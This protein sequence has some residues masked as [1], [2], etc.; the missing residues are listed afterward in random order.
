MKIRDF[1]VS[2]ILIAVWN[3]L[4]LGQA[5]VQPGTPGSKP[6]AQLAS[7]V[8][9]SASKA[10]IAIQGPLTGPAPVNL[11]SAGL[12]LSSPNYKTAGL[13]DVAFGDFNGDGNV[14]VVNVDSSTC[15]TFMPGDGKG[16]FSGAPV[17]SCVLPNTGGNLIVAGDFNN[18][19]ILDVAVIASNCCNPNNIYLMFAQG[20]G[21]GTF[22]YKNTI[23]FCWCGGG[24][25]LGYGEL[26]T[27]L[28]VADLNRDGNLDLVMTTTGGNVNHYSS[29][30]FLGSGNFN[31]SQ[32]GLVG[33][34]SCPGIAAGIVTDLNGDGLVDLA[35]TTSACGLH[36]LDVYLGNGDGTFQTP[37]GYPTTT[38]NPSCIAY[39]DINGDGVTDIA[40]TVGAGGNPIAAFLGNG[41]GT[42]G[43][44]VN[45]PSVYNPYCVAMGDFNG[46]GKADAIV[47]SNYSGGDVLGVQFSNGDGTFQAPVQYAVIT[48]PQRIFVQDVNGD[49]HPDW[50]SIGQGYLYL[51]VGLGSGHGGFLAAVDDYSTPGTYG[52]GTTNAIAAADFNKD[53]NLDY[54]TV[55]GGGV[56]ISIGDGAGNFA[57]AVN[58]PAGPSPSQFTVGDFNK[59]GYPDIAVTQQNGP[60]AVYVLLNNKNGTFASPVSYSVGNGPYLVQTGDF[61]KDGNLD[62][63]VTNV[64]DG[65]VSVLLGN[66]DGT[67]QGQKVSTSQTSGSYLA[68]ADFNG[69]GELDLAVALYSASSTNISILL[70][71]GDG[72]FQAPLTTTPAP[73]LATGLAAG[74]FDADGKI[75][76]V[77]AADSI[78]NGSVG[79]GGAAIY[80]GL[81]NGSFAKV[82]DYPTVPPGLNDSNFPTFRGPI[83]L[84]DLNNDGFLDIVAPNYGS[85]ANGINLGPAILLGKGD[86]TFILN[87]ATAPVAGTFQGGVALGDFNH[88]GLLDLAVRNFDPFGGQYLNTVTMLLS[89]E[90]T[91]VVL[92]SS[93]NPSVQGQPVTFT[94]TVVTSFVGLPTPTGTIT[95]ELGSTNVPVAL[96]NGVATYTTSTLSLGGT[97]VYGAYSGDSNFVAS[98]SLGLS[99]QVNPAP[100][101]IIT[102]TLP[103]AVQNVSYS[104]SV[105]ASG[106]IAPY[107]FN[108]FSGSLPTGLSLGGNGVISGTPTG[109]PGTSNFTVLVKDAENPTQSATANLSITVAINLLITTTSLP[110]GVAANAYNASIAASGGTP[111]YNFALSN[112]TTL[113]AGLSL[114]AAGAISG[115]PATPGTSNFT[116]QVTDSANPAQSAT[117]NLSITITSALSITTTSLPNG[118]QGSPYNTSVTATGGIAPYTFV[119]S[120]GNLPLGLSLSSSGVFSGTP[121]G[122]GTSNFTVKASDSSSPPQI[123]TASFSISVFNSL[124][125]TTTK[126]PGGVTGTSYSSSV[127][128]SG[129][130]PP[131]TFTI[132][133]GSLP[134]GLGISQGGRIS[135]TP[136]GSAGTSTFT[137]QAR[138]SAN[139]PQTST[140]ILSITIYTGLSITTTTLPNG[141]VGNV[142][143][144]KVTAF[145]GT[146][147]YAF[148][149]VSGTLPTGLT[150][151]TNGTISGTASSA[152]PSSFTVQATDS[153]VPVQTAMANLSIAVNPRLSISTT[154]LPTAVLG[155]PYN[156]TVSATGGVPPYAFSDT[157][158]SLPGGLTLS[159][160]GVIS[161][162]PT[163]LG[164]SNF[165]VQAVDSSVPS[166]L[167]TSKLSIK[168]TSNIAIT[169]PSVPNAVFNTPYNA[170]IT[171]TGGTAPYTFTTITGSLPAGLSLS[172]GGV[173][174]GTP[175]STGT[176]T[177]TVQAQDSSTPMLTATANFSI[178]VSG[179]LAITTPALLPSGVA[180]VPY[181]TK[182]VAAGGT[183]PYNFTISGGSLLQGLTLNSS[184]G[185]ISGTVPLNTGGAAAF[186]VQVT[187][188]STPV[189][190]ATSGF[191]L[192][193][194][195]PLSI[196]TTTLPGAAPGMPY[197]ATISTAGGS[198]PITFS[199]V[200]G[201]LPAGLSMSA[202]GVISGTP[203]GTNG[204][205]NFTLQAK[206]SAVPAQT[207]S[208]RLSITVDSPLVITTTS[209][210]NG[211]VGVPY[212]FQMMATGGLQPY[213]WTP[214]P[215]F[216]FPPGLTLSTTG[217]ISGTPTHALIYNVV[218][219]VQDT[220]QPNQMQEG[221]Y[222]MT[223]SP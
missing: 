133:S 6:D 155:I 218:V 185:V 166:Q 213:T 53:G 203:T 23:S 54:A 134:A 164:I 217:L 170:K 129:G 206:D 104:A 214:P 9:S 117:A 5:G 125:I 118:I 158:G 24:G 159:S 222:L 89:T 59:D 12:Y 27:S 96:V 93:A 184:S 167:S 209:I 15:I 205:S 81:G 101:V 3:I 123:A 88:D 98:T 156:A 121:S 11:L 1:S 102:T 82:V 190:M 144:S 119:I 55:G 153:S 103:D 137:V 75:D 66:G 69:D 99:Q 183:P 56:Y 204:V 48:A 44:A 148:T 36:E 210:P 140:A 187:D 71:N 112:G 161:G 2:F 107:N 201:T 29:Y 199:V 37:V 114:S 97:V 51:S 41:N 63:V 142:Y 219:N 120:S 163:S 171:A 208:R 34:G 151:G 220:S 135:G 7:A 179:N 195:G 110:N 16:H 198:P 46:D 14:D 70:G 61:N 72:T 176:S 128:A 181:K 172:S 169:T 74:D 8:G 86:G 196:S 211:K 90:G 216:M 67:F 80:L 65:T 4:A 124:G 197:S 47:S 18:D 154:S 194:A 87:P 186:D 100:L 143:N 111:P 38:G 105:S 64:T 52:S 139:P 43:T 13:L 91:E 132:S 168:A 116:V 175:S 113:P 191:S 126:L 106:G 32:A 25:Q 10:A 188:S 180:G 76:L 17:P 165:T 136:S 85:L 26:A 39:G 58:Y 62:L 223:V 42:F 83:S 108:L 149:V 189:Q 122:A 31:F 178:T 207:A 174:S 20:N 177:F 202:G 19:R 150:L 60:G 146:P 173:I 115:T 131:Y 192:V 78:N 215:G 30:V 57:T 84:G 94:A 138:D 152:G 200:S 68:V 212:H 28:N 130:L 95:F 182:I 35:T 147:P 109:L 22:T 33:T 49:G 45:S 141:V 160:A 50:V 145:G 40:V 92:T 77:V 73:L 157:V 21:D 221:V 162:T 79:A 127:A 193:I